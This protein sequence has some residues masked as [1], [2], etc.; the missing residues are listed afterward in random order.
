MPDPN[1]VSAMDWT[2]QMAL[3]EALRDCNGTS[4]PDHMVIVMAWTGSDVVRVIQCGVE[5]RADTN[6]LLVRAVVP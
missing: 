6:A 2:M 1:Q 5:K 4:P 3:D